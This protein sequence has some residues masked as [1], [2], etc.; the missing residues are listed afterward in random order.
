[1]GQALT[2]AQILQTAI[3][4]GFS[5]AT[6][7]QMTAIAMRESSGNPNATAIVSAQQAASVPGTQ[8][9]QSYGLWQIN[10]QG[11]PGLMAQLGITNPSQLLDPATNAR[12]AYLLYGNNPA[13][14]N[15]AW[16]INQPGYAQAYQ[17]NL[18]AAELA[19]QSVLGYD[20]LS[21]SPSDAT[22]ASGAVNDGS[23]TTTDP[24]AQLL[25]DLGDLTG[26]LDP[27]S[28]LI[29]GVAA[30]VAIALLKGT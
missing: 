10:I 6:A 19:A 8:A 30:I 17:A 9:E 1:M 23:D 7:T 21:G 18:P 20:P 4:A 5:P 13:N 25:P 15:T 22:T 28:L 2:P 11:N 29:L 12:A 27:T 16:Y 26:G 14:L 24:F 3:N